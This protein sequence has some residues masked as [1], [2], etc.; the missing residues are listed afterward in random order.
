[1]ASLL[2]AALGAVLLVAIV[3]R[4]RP[5]HIAVSPDS[6]AYHFLAA[7][8]VL[9][10][11]YQAGPT[12]SLRDYGPDT[13]AIFSG[14]RT[15]DPSV[16]DVPARTPGLP[17]ILAA[18]YRVHGIRPDVLLPYQFLFAALTA[19]AMILAGDVLWAGVGRAAGLLAVVAMANTP[20]FQYSVYQLL[21]EN[22]ACCVT[23][24]SLLTAAVAKQRSART[25]AAAGA[26][27][28]IGVL[29][30]PALV[31]VVL[32]YAL[33][34]LLD[35]LER[36]P[37]FIA[38]AVPVLL[39]LGSWGA[40]ATLHAGPAARMGDSGRFLAGTDPQAAA[41]IMGQ[42]PPSLD[43]R[44]LEEF[45][46]RFAGFPSDLRGNLRA[47]MHIPARAR[48]YLSIT[49]IKLQVGVDR[50][51]PPM[52][53]ASLI[54]MGLAGGLALD[55]KVLRRVGTTEVVLVGTAGAFRR[56]PM[57]LA[58]VC[59]EAAVLLLAVLGYSHPL[60][61]GSAWA[62]PLVAL[63][64]RLQVMGEEETEGRARPHW[65]LTWY[66]AYLMM[67]VTAFAIP[68][69]TRPFFPPFFLCAAMSLPLLAIA[70]GALTGS[71]LGGMDFRPRPPEG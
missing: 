25:E 57:V 38:F 24:L 67:I 16:S 23:A 32:A 22:L 61:V 8:L 3:A 4:D 33:F 20:E 13:A 26:A 21:T 65:L 51:P 29:V 5:P 12:S 31:F 64:G 37:R 69:F 17:L 46:T 48:E 56:R 6:E 15:V 68:R 47:A 55:R 28:A 62:F 59:V 1:V 30:R 50:L 60:L 39:I 52:W 34:I 18:I 7:N 40:F 19:M 42:R 49:I 35:P 27:M 43:R 44:S 45:W 63:L 9:G 54:G 53:I 10:R 14:A 11:G 2:V 66:V 70:L 36:R 41:A 58:V 71:R